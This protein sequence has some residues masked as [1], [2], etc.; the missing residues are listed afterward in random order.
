MKQIKLKLIKYY[1]ILSTLNIFNI[2]IYSLGIPETNFKG[3]S[4]LMALNVLRSTS[5]P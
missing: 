4:T 1:G 2:S 3:L 5:G